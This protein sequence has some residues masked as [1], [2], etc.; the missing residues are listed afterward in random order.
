MQA[1]P[2]HP[3]FTRRRHLAAGAALTGAAAVACGSAPEADPAP[4]Q[5][6]EKVTL[7]H[8]PWP[9][10][11]ARPSQ[12]AIVEAFNKSHP[13]IE[14]VEQILPGS[15][16]LYDKLLVQ[17]AANTLPD[18]TY[19]NETN[20]PLFSTKGIL[21]PIDQVIK[22]DRQFNEKERL[23]PVSKT[24]ITL[25]NKI[26]ALPV[27]SGTYITFFN[28]NMLAEA[29]VAAPKSGWTWQDVLDRGR[30]LTRD[31]RDTRVFGYG[32]RFG[33]EHVEPWII[34]NN[35]FY[36]DKYEFP[37][38]QRFDAPEVIE[39]VK[40]LHDL[41][42]RHQVVSSTEP[43]AGDQGTWLW[44]GK[45]AFRQEGAWMVADYAK[46]P[47]VSWGIAPLPKGKK[48]ATPFTT[49]LVSVT[50]T[51][52]DPDASYEFLKYNNKEG[53]QHYVKLWARM[54]VTDDEDT[55]K[56]FADYLKS[57][58]VDEWETIWN[59][60]KT[61]YGIPMSPAYPG[62]LGELLEPAMVTLFGKDGGGASVE[63]TLK[64]LGPVVQQ[65]LDQFGKPPA[66]K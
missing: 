57:N 28:K 33:F 9:G 18:S 11:P 63:N 61:G 35:A 56:M 65:R 4:K 12:T 21:A 46:Q 50:S 34:Q 17:A 43:G 41:V 60:R 62:I 26:W 16:N 55:R 15:G 51:S 48:E 36:F 45:N 10:G 14:I 44:Q 6:K 66:A 25:Q 7:Q 19:M 42:W 53:Q 24:A 37:T 49:G 2:F 5:R 54:P 8:T 39:A 31:V 20:V 3:H 13:D 30:R 22:K 32:Q 58:G 27:Q 52:K 64:A 1:R 59:A 23:T 29:G 38:K 40:Y 47:Q